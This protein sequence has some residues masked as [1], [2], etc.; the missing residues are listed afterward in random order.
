MNLETLKLDDG[1]C[2]SVHVK[3]SSDSLKTNALP[4]WKPI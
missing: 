1:L 2:D 3:S 4:R